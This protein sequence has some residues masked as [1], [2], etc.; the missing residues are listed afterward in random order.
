MWRA[1]TRPATS[2]TF[3]QP[4]GKSL[5]QMSFCTPP[6][7]YLSTRKPIPVRT[8]DI[9]TVR[10]R[11]LAFRPVATSQNQIPCCAKLHLIQRFRL[12]LHKTYAREAKICF[13]NRVSTKFAAFA[14][15]EQVRAFGNCPGDCATGV[16]LGKSQQ[17]KAKSAYAD[18]IRASEGGLCFAR[19]GHG[20]P[21]RGTLV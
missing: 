16:P 20:F 15:F 2:V 3:V 5:L 9:K 18:W 6:S 13:L 21:R 12:W 10:S 17:H 1:W 11:D 4:Q 7:G 14:A 8:R 19:S